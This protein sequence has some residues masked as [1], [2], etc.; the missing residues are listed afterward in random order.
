MTGSV[1]HHAKKKVSS[2][3]VGKSS[4]CRGDLA[5]SLLNKASKMPNVNI[6]YDATFSKMDTE[7]RFVLKD[8]HGKEASKVPVY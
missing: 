2:S 3:F 4:V 1:R 7:K 8:E 5:K 6:H